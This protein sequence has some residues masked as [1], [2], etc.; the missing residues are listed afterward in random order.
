MASDITVDEGNQ[1]FVDA[2]FT[3]RR[4]SNVAPFTSN[5]LDFISTV[6]LSTTN[7][8][9]LAGE[10]YLP[11][12]IPVTFGPEE[13]IRQLRVTVIG[14]VL[15]EP[16]EQFGLDINAPAAAS[17]GIGV[18]RRFAVATIREARIVS[19]R[20]EVTTAILSIRTTS[21]QRYALEFSPDLATW[22]VVP[23]AHDIVGTGGIV[24]VTDSLHTCC[25]PRFYRAQLLP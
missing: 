11:T 12:H 3:I 9:A 18:L 23:G 14:D 17:A 8:T 7:M 1:G 16:E 4:F 19:V 15:P 13:I 2:V 25:E 6:W 5:T 20:R 10:D 24:Q 21:S 22:S